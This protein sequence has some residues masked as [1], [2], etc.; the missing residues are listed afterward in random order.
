MNTTRFDHTNCLHPS[1][2]AGRRFC[3]LD[4][5][6]AIKGLQVAYLE[7]EASDDAEVRREYEARVDIFSQNWGMP[8][9][10]AYNLIEN[11]P[12]VF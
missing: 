3:R 5:K 2:P 4:L 8:L 10:D 7:M 1:T 9:R 12:V 6:M 11:G